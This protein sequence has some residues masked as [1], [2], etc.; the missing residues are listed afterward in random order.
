MNLD[1]RKPSYRMFCAAVAAALSLP[2]AACGEKPPAATATA[3]IESAADV[4]AR[5]AKQATAAAEKKK[6]EE[7]ARKADVAKKAAEDKAAAD[8]AQAAKVKAALVATPGLKN[9]ALD[10]RSSGA[11]VALFGTVDSKA[12]RRKAEKVAAQVPGVKSVK[13]ELKIV[14][15]S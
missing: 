5:E 10:V 8:T 6:A 11:E 1:Y 2:F 9:L 4:T 3:K 7:A 12:Q 13:N 15:G 14:K